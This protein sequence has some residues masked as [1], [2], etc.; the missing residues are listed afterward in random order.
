MTTIATHSS[1]PFENLIVNDQISNGFYHIEWNPITEEAQYISDT[2]VRKDLARSESSY[3]FSNFTLV[4]AS[5]ILLFTVVTAGTFVLTTGLLTKLIVPI[6]MTGICYLAR[7]YFQNILEEN[8]SQDSIREE[9]L[10]RIDERRFSNSGDIDNELLITHI[11]DVTQLDA[12]DRAREIIRFRNQLVEE[13]RDLP[14]R[15]IIWA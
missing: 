12:T 14:F 7:N 2:T 11:L 13:N 5:L 9:S 8:I 15:A 4:D 10:R 3:Y 6:A 1:V